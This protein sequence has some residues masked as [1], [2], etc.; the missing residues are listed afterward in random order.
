[1]VRIRKRVVG[2]NEYFYIEH[3]MKRIGKVEKKE[4]Y[5]GKKIPKDIE[6][7]KKAFLNEIYKEKWFIKFERISSAF[8]NEYKKMPMLGREKYIENFM[9]KFTYN[10]NRIEGSTLTLRETA[11]LLEEGITPKGKPVKF[12]KEA[13][14]HKKLFYEM[15]QYK[16][17]LGLG[18]VLHWHRLLF[19][20]TEPEIAGNIRKHQIAVS[21]SKTEFPVP[22]ELN[23]LLQDFFGWYNRDKTRLNPVELASLAHMRFVSI[24]PF[25]DGNG[26][27][28]RLIMNFILNRNGYPM[29]DIPYSNRNAYY[30][31]LERAQTK[32]EDYAF[33]QHIFRRYIKE[34]KK[35]SEPSK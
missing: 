24:H 22:A 29:L 9:I 34:H 32:K 7:I 21:G 23:A 2:S 6:K 17:D 27:I 13:E 31:A 20:N 3:T 26:R 33:V 12:V 16:K 14:A 30:T 18:I 15:L 25:T 19:E 11:S 28:S 8:R 1:M 4:R 5:I 10:T 35:Y